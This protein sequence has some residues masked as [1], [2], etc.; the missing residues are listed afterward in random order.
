[1]GST[2]LFLAEIEEVDCFVAIL[3]SANEWAQCSDYGIDRCVRQTSI[4]RMGV[5]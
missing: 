2:R 3:G 1:M 4:I 5:V